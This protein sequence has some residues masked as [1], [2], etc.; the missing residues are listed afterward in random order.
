MCEKCVSSLFTKFLSVKITVN[1]IWLKKWTWAK[2]MSWGRKFPMKRVISHQKID[3]VHIRINYTSEG[4]KKM[5]LLLWLKTKAAAALTEQLSLKASNL[6]WISSLW[7]CEKKR[8][9]V[10]QKYNHICLPYIIMKD[11][12]LLTASFKI[13][14]K[15]SV[16]TPPSITLDSAHPNV[17]IC[18]PVLYDFS[19]WF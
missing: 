1:I 10:E 4:H 2:S 14:Q 5:V 13:D 17:N 6:R 16:N 3:S 7:F 12:L 8:A 18:V 15:C 9:N 11:D 19:W